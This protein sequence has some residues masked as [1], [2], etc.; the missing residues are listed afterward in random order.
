[1]ERTLIDL[2]KVD[3]QAS[4]ESMVWSNNRLFSCGLHGF[5]LEHDMLTLKIKVRN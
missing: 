2:E 4:V 1:M 3:G 5:L